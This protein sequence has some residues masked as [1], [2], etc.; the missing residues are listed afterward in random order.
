MTYKV[1]IYKL[2]MTMMMIMQTPTAS[3]RVRMSRTMIQKNHRIK[4]KIVMLLQFLVIKDI[5]S[6]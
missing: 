2:I 5:K 6:R 3:I 1:I 4:K